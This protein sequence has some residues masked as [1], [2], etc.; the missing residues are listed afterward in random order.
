MCICV[1]G[2]HTKQLAYLDII[3]KKSILSGRNNH[4][5]RQQ[6]PQPTGNP[7]LD[8]KTKRK[9]NKTARSS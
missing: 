7:T 5:G 6:L 8:G 1:Q 3:F 2:D 9:I 4:K